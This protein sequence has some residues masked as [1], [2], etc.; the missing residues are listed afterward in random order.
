MTSAPREGEPAVEVAAELVGG[1]E[2]AIVVDVVVV[3]VM[4][5]VVVVVFT[6]SN[7]SAKQIIRPILLENKVV[8]VTVSRLHVRCILI[9]GR[10]TFRSFS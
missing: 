9:C 6:H 4:V 8:E 3:V 1:E 2:A 7:T 10:L 5:V